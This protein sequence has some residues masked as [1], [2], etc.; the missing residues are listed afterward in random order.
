[1][2]NI[3]KK[4]LVIEDDLLILESIID[5]L[6]DEGFEIYSAL[7]GVAGIQ[8][9]IEVI[10]DLII[11][12]VSMPKKDGFEVCRTLQQIPSVCNVPF[13]FLTA[14]SLND[15]IRQG[16]QLGAD[17]YL[18][19]PFQF[20]ELL[21]II[22]IRLD[23]HEKYLN[24]NDEQFFALIDNP[25]VGVFVYNNNKFTYTNT[26]LTEILGYSKEEL[27]LM[28]FEDMISGEENDESLEKI[29]RCIKGIQNSFRAELKIVKKDQSLVVIEVYGAI[30]KINGKECLRGNMLEVKSG[31][32]IGLS[33]GKELDKLKFSQREIEVMQLICQGLSTSE[34]SEKLF[35]SKHTIDTHRAN[36]I[37]KTESRNTADLVMYAIRNGL[38]EL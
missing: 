5:F 21:K 14:K 23:K 7:D 36:L 22:K 15:D 11:S 25:L 35:L 33:D 27:R 10:P 34:I 32:E 3:M 38:V 26:K 9:A 13:I 12:D 2:P 30:V 20:S 16:M 1:M 29:H 4:I 31:K 24:Q 28:S 17:D 18:T 37:A 19:K 6:K 8:A